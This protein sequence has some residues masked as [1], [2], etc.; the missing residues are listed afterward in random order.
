MSEISG[1]RPAKPSFAV[2]VLAGAALLGVLIIGK[3]FLIPLTVA[4]MVF[5]L[6]Q[7]LI[8][9]IKRVSIGGWSPPGSLALILSVLF[10]LSLFYGVVT[11][12]STQFDEVGQV[13]PQYIDRAQRILTDL[14]SIVGKEAADKTLEALESINLVGAISGVVDSAGG[15]LLN[16][17]LVAIY[18][19]FLLAERR[20]FAR[21]IAAMFPVQADA[22]NAEQTVFAVS[23]QVSRYIGL[24]TVI[25]LFTGGASYLVLRVMGVDFAETWALLIFLL[26]FIPNIGSVLGVIL[27][28]LLSLV[29]FDTL[30][31]VLIIAVVLT[32]LQFSIGNIIEPSFMGRSLNLSSFVIIVSLA[33]WGTI[34]GIAGAFLSVPI[35]VVLLIICSAIPSWRWF[36]ILL[37]ADGT[38]APIETIGAEM[39]ATKE[40]KS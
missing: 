4:F 27:P 3:S 7:T 26:N 20:N 13:G 11:I 35:T 22:E 10:V 34:W 5:T 19:A 9:N 29:Q 24:K 1:A 25:S 21:K 8:E 28:V 33:F 14:M 2:A 18:V 32:L 37:S 39:A 16:T 15:F 38:P 36:A 17:S 30:T 12:I 6:L 23:H 31:P 40:A